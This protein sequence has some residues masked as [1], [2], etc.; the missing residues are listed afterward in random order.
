MP[1]FTVSLVVAGLASLGLP[2]TSGFVSE[3]TIF[4]GAFPAFK[5]ATIIAAFG[6]VLTAAYILWM[7]QRSMFGPEKERFAQIGDATAVQVIPIGL[8]IVSIIGVGIY[9]AFVSDVFTEGIT[10]MLNMTGAN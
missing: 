1:V 4:L 2:G 9:P 7:I 5:L 6:V 8:L 10:E 3:I